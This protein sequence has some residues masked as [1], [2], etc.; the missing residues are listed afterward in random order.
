[1]FARVCPLSRL[2]QGGNRKTGSGMGLTKLL[3]LGPEAA[4]GHGCLG[5]LGRRLRNGMHSRVL[6]Q[7]LQRGEMLP[8]NLAASASKP[9]Q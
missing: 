7:S 5:G 2:F 3:C 4:V 8:L 9:S 1:M 6:L